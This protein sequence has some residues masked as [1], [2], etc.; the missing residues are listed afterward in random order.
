MKPFWMVFGE[1]GREP[2]G[3]HERRED[4]VETAKTLATNNPGQT[5]TLVQPTHSYRLTHGQREV[6]VFTHDDPDDMAHL[7]QAVGALN[8]RFVSRHD[9]LPF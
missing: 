6:D 4:A 1:G 7:A 3:R 8:D 2:Y 5:F 9:D